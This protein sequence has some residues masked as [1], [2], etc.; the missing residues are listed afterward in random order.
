MDIVSQKIEIK[1]PKQGRNPPV[2][3]E[4]PPGTDE[5]GRKGERWKKEPDAALI[6]RA[7]YWTKRKPPTWHG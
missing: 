7:A 3:R 2:C 4:W 5:A 1:Q 6:L